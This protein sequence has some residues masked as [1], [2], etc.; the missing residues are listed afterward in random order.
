[1]VIQAI[2]NPLLIPW[3][4]I[5]VTDEKN[6]VF[7]MEKLTVGNPL[8]ATILILKSDFSKLEGEFSLQH[9]SR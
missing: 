6:L 3:E 4:E 9:L 1:M 2:F 5:K 7:N 8:V